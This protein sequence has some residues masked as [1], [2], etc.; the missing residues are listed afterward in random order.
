MHE[1]EAAQEKDFRSILN[2]FLEY[3]ETRDKLICEI[4]DIIDRIDQNRSPQ[5]ETKSD[6]AETPKNSVVVPTLRQ[7]AR[8]MDLANEKLKAISNRL[9]KLA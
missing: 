3:G 8:E 6:L 7:R 4:D 9:N 2:S 5:V 1:E